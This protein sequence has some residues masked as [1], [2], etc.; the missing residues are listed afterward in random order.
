LKRVCV[1]ISVHAEPSRLHATLASLRADTHGGVELLLL[2]DGPDEET[3]AA[4]STLNGLPQ[5]GT[6]G[7]SGDA[8]CFNR[9]AAASDADVLVL[10]ESGALV[11]PRW[12]DLLL[13]ALGADER[14]GLAG[15]STNRSWNEQGAFPSAGGSHAEVARAA[16]AAVVRFGGE[17]RGLAP[18]Y[19]LADFCYAARREVV[20][21][22]GPA[23]EGYGVGPCWEMDYN[24]R[25]ERAG[26]RGVWAC[27]AYV[28]RAPFTARRQADERRLFEA[29]KRRYQDK[30]CGA[31]LRGEKADYRQHCRGDACANFAPPASIRLDTQARTREETQAHSREGTHARTREETHAAVE[32]VPIET[33]ARSAEVN[34]EAGV[35]ASVEASS[36]E[37]R[38]EVVETVA[39]L[40]TADAPL[41]TCIMPTGDRRMFVPQAVR[42]FLR[43]DYPNAELL[44]LDDGVDS[45]EDCVPQ[46]ERV[47]YLR[48]KRK[49]SVGA[50]RNLACEKARGEIIVHWDD[51]DWYP[52]WRLSAQVKAL[53]EGGA[54]V[55]GTSRLIYYEAANGRAWRYEYGGARSPWVAG[56]TLAYRRGFWERHRFPDVRVGEDTR[57]VWGAT[58]ARVRD[59][60]EPSLC[61]A[62]V[63]AANTSPKATDGCFW[64]PHDADEVRRLLGDE[65]HLYHTASL[66]LSG[67]H[68]WPRVTCIMPTCDR[69]PFVPL[70]LENFRRQDYPNKELVVVDDGCDAIGDLVEG[71]ADVRYVRLSTRTS[72]GGKR[73]LA[74]RAPRGRI[75]AHWDDD[76]WYAPDR[77]R[78]QIAPIMSGEA[79][80]TGLVN[81]CVL[82]LPRGDFWTT[83]PHL[84][85][86]MFVGDVHGGT[87]VYRS[88]LLESGLRYPETSLA[89][90]AAL[91]RQA[92]SRR[93]Q[94][95]RLANPGLFVYVRHGSNA[96][97]EYA[98]GSFLDPAGWRR[99]ARPQS[100][101]D[102]SL[103]E[104]KS[105]SLLARPAPEHKTDAS[106]PHSNR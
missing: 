64:R 22:V 20:E 83:L 81:D 25:A 54:D 50:K 9:L 14:H 32:P 53:A 47:R 76:D 49:L 66:A 28:W 62:T 1:G 89:E 19:S 72:I 56:N 95:S 42:S 5:S 90:D 48:L 75:I 31:R 2:P 23:D 60:A 80:L 27:S 18:L 102:G 43:Q 55:C 34:V 40:V 21:A 46:S 10:L 13:A 52:A 97:R 84:H 96:W 59:L 35:E 39:P 79:D 8:A 3:A 63:H 77:L 92:A 15:P 86:R 99:I 98:P 58:A 4:L 73:N 36:L 100:F 12:L 71:H 37:T 6:V 69:R 74:C 106:R 70:A 87:L 45:V 105:A 38:V 104:Y 11:S 82:E 68:T 93:Y 91:I 61:V 16:R 65:L 30:F 88:S 7:P 24:V 17:V 103:E 85:R 94:L 51:D 29:N 57:F 26:F 67:T 78:Y 44:V 33:Y 41:V 101:P